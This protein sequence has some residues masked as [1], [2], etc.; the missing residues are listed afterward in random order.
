[1]GKPKI[2]GDIHKKCDR[3]GEKSTDSAA[4]FSPL[5][6]HNPRLQLACRPQAESLLL[7]EKTIYKE[8]TMRRQ[9][10]PR[11]GRVSRETKHEHY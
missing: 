9:A 7:I 6:C 5:K 1:M 2:F 4:S 11:I 10:G 3:F 8:V